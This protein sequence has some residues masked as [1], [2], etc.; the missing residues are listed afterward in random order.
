MQQRIKTYN[1]FYLFYLTQ[2][3]KLWT[4]VFHFIAILLVLAVI[5]YVIQSGKERFLWYVPIY[6]LGIS[7]L[8]HAIFEKNRP[9]IMSYPAWSVISDMRMFFE[10]LIGKQKFKA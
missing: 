8:S 3:S 4:R 9:T 2:H 7:G 10:L 6:G 1:E 5:I